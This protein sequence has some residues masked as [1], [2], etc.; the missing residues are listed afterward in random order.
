VTARP[1]V[2]PSI[3]PTVITEDETLRTLAERFARAPRVALDTEAASF[4]RYVDRMYLLQLSSDR[5]TVLVDPLT[6]TDLEPVGRLLAAPDLEIILHDADYD[7]R[8]LHRDYGFAARNIWDTRVAAQLCGETAFGLGALLERYFGIRLSKQLQRADWSLRPLTDDMI[9][10]A[11]ADTAYLPRLR[12][13]LAERLAALGRRHWVEEEFLRLEGVRWTARAAEGEEFLAL[14]GAKLLRPQQLAVLRALWEWRD[15]RARALDRAPFRVA[16][17]EM[18][19]ALARECPTGIESLS[20]VAGVPPS[21]ARRHGTEFVDAIRAARALPEDQW[22][23]LERRRRERPDPDLEE[24]LA[25]LK[26]L[27]GERAPQVGL[28]PG[29]VC[30]NAVLTAIA[31]LRPR[32]SADLDAVPDL[33]RWQREIL[34]DQSILDAVA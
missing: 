23:R 9:A 10:Y 18:L 24:R 27:R 20:R 6:V 5:E 2:P 25:R 22:P 12:D 29:L 21:I 1:G 13:L 16:G 26:T 11:A 7:L 4:H 28:D 17:N 31:R 34:G 8:I 15:A 19:V 30:A 14:K 3:L 33:R 32:S